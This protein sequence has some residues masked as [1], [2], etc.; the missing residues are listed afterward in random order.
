MTLGKAKYGVDAGLSHPI[1]HNLFTLK[2]RPKL[3]AQVLLLH[4]I[5][6]ERRKFAPVDHFEATLLQV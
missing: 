6:S 3:I 2:Q 5:Y 4:A 1:P